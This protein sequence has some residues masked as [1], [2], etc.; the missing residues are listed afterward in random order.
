MVDKKSHDDYMRRGFFI[1][2]NLPSLR[3]LRYFLGQFV[4]LSIVFDISNNCN[5]HS[6][7]NNTI[8]YPT[9]YFLYRQECKSDTNHTK[10][11][12]ILAKQRTV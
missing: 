3:L 10:T 11:N 12:T 7:R 5:N 9:A 4:F 1:K 6:H 8:S 2:C